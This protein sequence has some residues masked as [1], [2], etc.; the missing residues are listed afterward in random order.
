MARQKFTCDEHFA[1]STFLKLVGLFKPDDIHG[2]TICI[3]TV[4]YIYLYIYINIHK[5]IIHT[6]IL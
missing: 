1:I 3:H 2:H 5:H 4:L 6:H